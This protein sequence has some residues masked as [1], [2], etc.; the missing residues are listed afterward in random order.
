[1]PYALFEGNRKIGETLP[2]E[3]EVWKRALQSGL[4]AD[5]P[6]AD[7]AGGQVLPRGYH[8]RHCSEEEVNQPSAAWRLPREIS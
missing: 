4:I 5:I 6:V 1:M 7:E 8:V 2:S 3:A